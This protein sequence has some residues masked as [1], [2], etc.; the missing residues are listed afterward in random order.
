M[1]VRTRAI[2]HVQMRTGECGERNKLILQCL[3]WVPREMHRLEATQ[4]QQV[5]ARTRAYA[6]VRVHV[7][8]RVGWRARV[9]V[10]VLLRKLLFR[11]DKRVGARTCASANSRARLYMEWPNAHPGG[12]QPSDGRTS[13]LRSARRS[14]ASSPPAL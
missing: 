1:R 14:C 13:A 12:S 10:P 11:R 3:Q 6:Y 7:R 8:M 5:D 9:P 2:V 4:L